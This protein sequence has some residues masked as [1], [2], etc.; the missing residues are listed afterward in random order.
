MLKKSLKQFHVIIAITIFNISSLYVVEDYF[1]INNSFSI[2]T[3]D[4]ESENIDAVIIEV[5][6]I[7]KTQ[8]LSLTTTEISEFAQNG[9]ITIERTPV[10]LREFLKKGK[11]ITVYHQ[12]QMIGYLLL[13][14]MDGY[15]NWAHG[16]QFDSELNLDELK[17]LNYIDQ[18]AVLM[19]F[20]GRGV[21]TA[22]VNYAK[23]LS[24]QG[25]LTDTLYRPYPNLA[26]MALFENNG[27]AKL[28][29]LYVEATNVLPAHQ[30]FLMLWLP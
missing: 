21:E 11:I 13:E 15:I 5:L 20:V 7:Q 1:M 27:F 24:P 26:S 18:I 19:S 8:L 23:Y 4:I 10:Y 3:I 29:I 17:T 22:L 16:R 30:I 28:G 9:F 2:Q 14:N 6:A 12:D 25:I